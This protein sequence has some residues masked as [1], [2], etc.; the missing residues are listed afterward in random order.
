[1]LKQIFIKFALLI[2]LLIFLGLVYQKWFFEGDL[3]KHSEII[4]LIRNV[5]D[6][7]A[8]IYLGESSNITYRANDIDKRSI[9]AFLGDYFPFI[10]GYRCHQTSGSCRCV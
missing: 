1:M 5:P 4:N 3:Q 9:S 8:V 6:S 2:V 7:A 10:V